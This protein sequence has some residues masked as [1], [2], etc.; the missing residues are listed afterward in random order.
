MRKEVSVLRKSSMRWFKN[1]SAGGKTGVYE[2]FR[3]TAAGKFDA[4]LFTAVAALMIFGIIM[5]YSA[6]S[7]V[8][9]KN[10]GDDMYFTYKQIF[11]VVIAL[12]A[13]LGFY[14]IDYHK[15]LKRKFI[16]LAVSF[17]LLAAVFIP[18][19]GVENYG[20]K[21]WIKFPF[22]T[23]Q[24][25][26]IA[27]FGFVIFSAAYL[28]G[29]HDKIFRFRYLL[30]VIAAG[31]AMCFMIMLEPNMSVTVCLALIMLVMLFIGGAKLRHFVYILAP[32]A[33]A[34]PLLIVAEPY[35]LSRLT[36]FLNPWE[37]ALEE[38]YQLIQSLYALG[39]GGFFGVGIFNSRQKYLFLPFAESDFIFSVI[40]EELGLAGALCVIAV[41]V[42]IVG[43]II[44]AAQKAPDREGSYLAGGIAAV[45]AVQTVVNIAVVTGSIPPTGVPLPFVSAG[46]SSL[47]AFCAAVGMALN[48]RKQ[49]VDCR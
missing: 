8:S 31:G 26:E 9:L 46:S 49:S 11:G 15:L 24:S 4:A 43:R 14:F 3:C 7:Y 47:I 33:C 32:M 38:G 42:F 6:S 41:Y 34:V 16:V 20:A 29:Y 1:K 19:V 22:F 30:P 39:S 40:G 28:A 44:V 12:C 10:Y 37:N 25:S 5:V 48:I 18:G 36:A 27:K 2:N 21:R 23:L 35:R 17:L 13:M 45:I